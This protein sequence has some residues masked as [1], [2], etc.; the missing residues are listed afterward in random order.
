MR[1]SPL[2][3]LLLPLTLAL[4]CGD[5]DDGDGAVDDTG[6]AD[7]G[8][9][10]DGGT[11]AEQGCI[12][13][14]GAGG[15]A[16][17][18]DAVAAAA[19]GAE[20]SMA[21]CPAGTHEEDIL[22]DKAVTLVGSPDLLLAADEEDAPVRITADGAAARDLVV[23]GEKV[24][25]QV[26]GAADVRL[27][28]ITVTDP[29]QWGVQAVDATGLQLEEVDVSG[30][31]DGGVSIDGG[32]ATVTGLR[33]QDGKGYGLIAVGGAE[34]E[35][36]SSTFRSLSRTSTTADDSVGIAAE[37]ATLSTSGNVIE[38][39]LDYGVLVLGGS[40][41]L[42]GDQITGGD[43]GVL[44]SEADL[45]AEG[46]SITDAYTCGIYAYAPRAAEVAGTTVIGTPGAVLEVGPDEW[47]EAVYLSAGL[48]L[49]APT[50]AITDSSVSGYTGVGAF[51]ASPGGGSSTMTG[52]T[53]AD[54]GNHGLYA[55]GVDLTATD[56][57]VTGTTSTAATK[58][59]ACTTVDS[60]VG[61]LF[62][63]GDLDWT[64]GEIRDIAGY[65]LTGI[66]GQLTIDGITVADTDC[67]GI[68]AFQAD[69]DIT[70]GTFSGAPGGAFASAICSYQSESLYVGGSSFA[71]SRQEVLD[72][73]EE[74]M[75]GGVLTRY[76]YYLWSGSDIQV[77]YGADATITQN[78]FQGGVNGVELYSD[79]TDPSTATLTNNSFTDYLGLVL[80]V[81]DGNSASATDLT[82]TGHGAYALACENGSL[83][84][85]RV[86]VEDGGTTTSRTAVYTGDTWAYDLAIDTTEPSVVAY[87]CTVEAADLT[88]RDA[89]ASAV[90]LIDGSWELTD[91]VIDGAGVLDQG[92]GL[93]AQ[94]TY[95]AGTL[96][97]NGAQ[98]DGVAAGRG[99]YV[100]AQA[101]TTIS[102][103]GAE[104]SDTSDDGV[105]LQG[106]GAAGTS[107]A[108]V[109]GLTVSGAGGAGLRLE[110]LS[111]SLSAV[112]VVGSAEDGIVL[113]G[114]TVSFAGSSSQDNSGFGMVCEES[115]SVSACDV[116][117]TGNAEGGFDGCE[118]WC[119]DGG[120][121]DG[122][123]AD[124]GAADPS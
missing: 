119:G 120:S 39:V 112:S 32:S 90:E 95:T 79:G 55:S 75:S 7:G 43:F 123:A 77:W 12:T 115:V 104:V 11:T 87:G 57:V 26:E 64:G 76:D 96:Y 2:L 50:T 65:G 5:K 84:L 93:S 33:V 13:V 116:D 54:Q 62:Y 117:T 60:Q 105:H 19:E 42:S 24:G 110:D 23:E 31:D 109:N 70:Y 97:L 124:G 45:S 71:D 99:I 74:F 25:V 108:T 9:T 101:S 82:V 66:Y 68:M 92:D 21:A 80:Y 85:D 73:S 27:T 16:W 52:V 61:V 88:V 44:A 22:L 81:G 83:D 111:A 41:A 14:D 91:L 67:A 59:E 107:T 94:T 49:Y 78:V 3:S 18:N 69:A 36:S 51:V 72:R 4:A 53:L 56:V 89:D 58:E 37:E 28:A 10:G 29:A 47:N 100:G 114:G 1:S 38:D 48:F 121:G 20:I 34:V 6:T 17:V 8:G 106:L 46:L 86:T 30:A 40:A 15:F 63:D 102:I 122:G 35:V 103:F 118:A 98:I 113:T